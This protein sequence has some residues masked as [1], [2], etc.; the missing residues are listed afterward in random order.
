LVTREHIEAIS[1]GLAL[2]EAQSDPAAPARYAVPME[3]GTGTTILGLV[4]PNPGGLQPW[5]VDR[6]FG[7]LIDLR[8]PRARDVWVRTPGALCVPAGPYGRMV[9]GTPLPIVAKLVSNFLGLGLVDRELPVQEEAR[10]TRAPAGAAPSL[11]GRSAR[12]VDDGE[13]PGPS[14][15]SGG[16]G[17]W[18]Q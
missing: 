3:W 12:N 17:P 13:R 10:T 8:A 15:S 5:A 11:L 4:D 2:L 6:S 9:G 16:H 14:G 7:P 1:V 18:R